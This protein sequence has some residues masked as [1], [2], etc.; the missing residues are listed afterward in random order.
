VVSCGLAGDENEPDVCLMPGGGGGGTTASLINVAFRRNFTIYLERMLT[1]QL[2]T[3]LIPFPSSNCTTLAMV[4]TF[5]LAVSFLPPSDIRIACPPTMNATR[6]FH[7]MTIAFTDNV[8]SAGWG[9]IL[10]ITHHQN[11]LGLGWYA[12]MNVNANS[13]SPFA[14]SG[15]NY[16]NEKPAVA[17]KLNANEFVLGWEF[18]DAYSGASNAF[19]AKGFQNTTRQIIAQRL[20]DNNIPLNVNASEL[21]NVTSMTTGP[22]D[23]VSISRG[24]N[25]P[26]RY[27]Y[28][29]GTGISGYNSLFTGVSLKKER[30]VEYLFLVGPAI[31]TGIASVEEILDITVFPN[32]ANKLDGSIKVALPDGLASEIEIY[33]I[34]GKLVYSETTDGVK[35]LLLENNYE[36]GTYVIHVKTAMQ[37]YIS[38]L[39]V[40]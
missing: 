19:W 37:H 17:Y 24:N 7:D 8:V 29:D 27:S 11:S 5:S 13:G 32:P 26:M 23:A 18:S 38:K 16:V 3:G 36:S 10:T 30:E 39:V 12:G 4:D 6:G 33:S 14:P 34:T 22:M 2:V 31:P 25:S 1:T 35:E 15:A 28:S 21:N 9:D 40:N 20:G